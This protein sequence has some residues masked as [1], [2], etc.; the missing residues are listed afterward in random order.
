M[1]SLRDI[2]SSRSSGRPRSPRQTCGDLI[3]RESGGGPSIRRPPLLLSGPPS[4]PPSRTWSSRQSGL[5]IRVPALQTWGYHAGLER[6][7]SSRGWSLFLQS[8]GGGNL[9]IGARLLDLRAYVTSSF[10]SGPRVNLPVVETF[11]S[12]Y[13]SS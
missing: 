7:P 4:C 9:E 5:L 2:R 8:K 13:V 6:A 12:S 10:C 1:S 3:G 11:T